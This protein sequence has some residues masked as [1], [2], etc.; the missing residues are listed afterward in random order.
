MAGR[1]I[2]CGLNEENRGL[3]CFCKETFY[4]FS[5]VCACPLNSYITNAGRCVCNGN[6]VMRN[7]VC[8]ANTVPIT[9][10]PHPPT[11]C[12]DKSY[13][14]GTHCICSPP[15]FLIRGTCQTCDTHG[16]YNYNTQ[17]CECHAGYYSDPFFCLPCHPTC[18]TCFR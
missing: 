6:T 1:C 5:G 4:R 15:F 14:N 13:W 12:P 9:P 10:T 7:G 11:P 8:V 17:K 18:Q 16:I 2:R 3:R